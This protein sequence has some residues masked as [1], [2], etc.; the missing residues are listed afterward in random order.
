MNS[1]SYPSNPLSS[2][3]YC[4]S[5][6][7]EN[8]DSS[9]S[10]PSAVIF[11]PIL[12]TMMDLS[13]I[14]QGD[15]VDGNIHFEGLNNQQLHQDG[16]NHDSNGMENANANNLFGFQEERDVDMHEYAGSN[17]GDGID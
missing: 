9:S 1:I 6:F 15:C 8:C 2:G 4:S 5:P 11:V 3:I 17:N 12:P 7:Q 14:I 10:F 16:I 13:N